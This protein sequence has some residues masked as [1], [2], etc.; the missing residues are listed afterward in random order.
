MKEAFGEIRIPLLKDLPFFHELTASG[1]GRV[2][3]QGEVGTVFSYNGGVDCAPVQDLRFRFNY[4]RAV[5]APN[6]SETGFPLVPNFLRLS[7][8]PAIPLRGIPVRTVRA[9]AWPI[10]VRSYL[11]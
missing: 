3:Y 7:P 6:V 2:R 4:S 11:S 9:T 5:R 10:L 1:A 8:I